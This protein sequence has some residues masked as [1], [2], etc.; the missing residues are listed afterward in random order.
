MRPVRVKRV[1]FP[2]YIIV[3]DRNLGFFLQRVIYVVTPCG[4]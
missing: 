1:A 3:L 4:R 2:L